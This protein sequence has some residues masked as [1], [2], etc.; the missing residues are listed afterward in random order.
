[1]DGKIKIV[2]RETP[3]VTFRTQKGGVGISLKNKA[4]LLLVQ[5]YLED[6]DSLFWVLH[7]IKLRIQNDEASNMAI[8]AIEKAKK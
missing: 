5:L 1:M 4:L 8:A 3:P 6:K 7:N 2:P